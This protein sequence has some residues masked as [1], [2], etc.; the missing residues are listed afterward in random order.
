[1]NKNKYTVTYEFE[2]DL[3]TASTKLGSRLKEVIELCEEP[4]QSL[5]AVTLK[6]KTFVKMTLRLKL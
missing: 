1:M 2:D 5:K 4:Y 3:W 6:E